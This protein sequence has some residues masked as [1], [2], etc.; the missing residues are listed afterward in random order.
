MLKVSLGATVAAA[1]GVLLLGPAS[2]AAPAAPDPSWG[3]DPARLPAL[4]RESL[5][6]VAELTAQACPELPPVWVL[7]QVQAESGWDPAVTSVGP[8]GAAGL[9]RFDERN[10]VAAGGAAWPSDPPGP[11]ADVTS[12]PDHL[13]VAVPWVCAN[14]RAVTRHLETTGKPTTP[15]DAMLVCHVARCGRVTGS[16]TGVPKPG[17][18]GCADRCAAAIDR[19]L[20]AVHAGVE[21]FSA[22]PDPA[23]RA[24]QAAAPAPWT[25]GATSCDPPDPTGDGCLTGATRHGLEA[26]AAAFGGW[27]GGPV[28]H[29]AGCWDK[30]AWN[31]KSDHSRGRACDLFPTK[32]GHF[33]DGAELDAGWGVARW[34]QTNAG[35]L[36]VKY[37]IWQGR[38]WDPGVTDDGGWGR[39]YTGA[40]VYDVR[41]ATGGHF[42]HVHVSFRE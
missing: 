38:Y 28:I 35:P 34:F 8:G 27:S 39:R 32:P 7:A 9:Y 25:G 26:A 4:A 12:A 30:H 21:R 37:L 17:E 31:P 41:D 11:D 15:L 24:D 14:L 13:R 29:S 2:A 5:P 19:Y 16:A 23:P 42:D 33:A 10:W 36:K 22:P 6:L 40:G 18:A 1:L 3:V 20:A